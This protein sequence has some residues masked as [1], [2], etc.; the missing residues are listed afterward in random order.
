[1]FAAHHDVV[2]VSANYR[3][4]PWG[5]LY[6]G[7]LDPDFADGSNL[8]VRDQLL[9]LRWVRD[10]IARF[11]GDPGNVTLFGLSTGA[12]DVATLLGVPAARGLFHQAAIYSGSADQVGE[13]SEAAR[14]A[15]RFI[16]AA[17]SLAQTPSELV[18]LSNTALRYIHR[19]TIQGG[20]A[21]YDPVVDGDV[22]HQPPLRS[23]ADGSVSEVPL[24]VSVTSDEARILDLVRGN[25]VDE[26]YARLVEDDGHSGGSRHGVGHDDKISLLSRKLYVEPAERLLAAATGAGG[27][28][29]AQVFDYH[30]TTSHLAGNPLVSGKPVH[31]ADTSALF[32][33]VHGCAGT[34]EDRAVGAEEQRALI[35]LARNGRP[36][37]QRYTVDRPVAKWLNPDSTDT[38]TLGALPGEP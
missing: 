15:E 19:R 3:L 25:A 9:L 27:H 4:G 20:P 5:W 21:R 12:S 18:N 10:N 35:D 17:E 26:R 36:D 30:P 29:W 6:L 8:A 31:G 14:F 37:W 32:C 16:A 28:C 1:M 11:G 7:A 38:Q 13:L 33:D 34:D 23:I 2:I 24:L 22:L